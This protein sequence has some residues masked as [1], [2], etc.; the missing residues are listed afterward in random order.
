MSKHKSALLFLLAASILYSA[1]AHAESAAVQAEAPTTGPISIYLDGSQLESGTEPMIVDGAV[2]VP[3]RGLFEA[4]GAKVIWDGGSKTVTATKGDTTLTYQI[5]QDTADLN[6]QPLSL[7]VPGQIKDG[8]TLVPLRFV[9]EALGS[10]V[11]W[12]PDSRTVQVNSFI[13]ETTVLRELSLKSA[14]DVQSDSAVV[15]LPA[16]E[17]VHVIGEASPLWLEVRTRDNRTGYITAKPGF[18][19]YSSP[20]L[21]EA[22]AN[23][24][25]AFGTTFLGTPYEYGASP[26]QTLTFDCSSFVK[27]VFSDILGMD[28]PRISSD[29]AKQGIE[30]GMNEL[31]TGDLLFFSSQGQNIDHVAIY[32]GN[33]QLLHTYSKKYGVRLE[34]FSTHWVGTFVTARRVL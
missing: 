26:N 34:D 27:R 20:T 12:D 3:M 9:S 19:D 29:Q 13:L 18:T 23:E 25:I 15:L 28:L 30:I 21:L 5:G 33:N 6:G 10:T 7:S 32:A 22:Q 11:S 2:L 14:P 4:Q 31:R 8:Y 16:G 17:K 1:P 24:L